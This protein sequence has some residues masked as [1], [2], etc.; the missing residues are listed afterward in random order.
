MLSGQFLYLLIILDTNA[1]VSLGGILSKID[2]DFNILVLF[3]F[4]PVE[5]T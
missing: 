2:N 4:R 3:F 1:F 5:H